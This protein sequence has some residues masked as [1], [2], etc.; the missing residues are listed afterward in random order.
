MTAYSLEHFVC[1]RCGNC[2]R[3][4]GFVIITITDARRIADFLE[5]SVQEFYYTYTK[6]MNDEYRLEDI[7]GTKDCIFLENNLCKIHPVKPQQCRDFPWK[8]RVLEMVH[9]CRALQM[10]KEHDDD[11]R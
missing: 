3:G 2:C 6:R 1:R 7:P 4:D 8:W 10:Q 11:N 9:F 5:I